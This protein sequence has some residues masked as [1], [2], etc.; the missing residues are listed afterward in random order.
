MRYETTTAWK[1]KGSSIIFD[2]AEIE[3]L[4]N[5]DVMISLRELLSW[6]E[7]RLPDTPPGLK[8]SVLVCGLEAVLD[9]CEP[10]AALDFLKCRIRPV[11]REIQTNWTE[12]GLIFGF[13]GGG[14]RFS[15]TNAFNDEILYL[16][17]GN[18]KVQISN[19]LWGHSASSNMV[20]LLDA[21]SETINGKSNKIGYYVDRI[22]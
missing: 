20:C 4:V 5:D 21:E 3:C 7:G 1:R 11:I 9:S 16:G 22:S 13:S 6:R 10:D 17:T 18:K 2:P 14:K 19:G 8:D 12:T 15:E